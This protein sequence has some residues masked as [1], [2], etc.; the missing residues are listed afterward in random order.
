MHLALLNLTDLMISLWRGTIDCTRPDDKATW[1][2]A[3]F[4]GG[5]LWQQH[6]QAVA[7]ALHYLP[8]SFDR[9]P[10][11][12]A[13][14]LTSSYKAWEFLLYL[15]G[16]GP[17][18][19]YGTLPNKYFTNYCKL[20]LGIWLMNQ[21]RITQDNVRKAHIALLSFAHEFELIYCQ[22]L[23]TC[24]HFVRPCM[25]SLVHLPR[26]VIR[27]GLP[28]CSSQWT[29]AQTIGNLGKE[30]KQHSNPFAN[31]SQHGIRHACVNALVVI[32][33]DLESQRSSGEQ[34]SCGSKDLGDGYIL[35][36][37]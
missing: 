16:L 15:Y 35:L 3:V 28:I 24:I 6:G 36:C 13:E 4:H 19:L 29:L 26:K 18:L 14:K 30:I 31:L 12:I 11:N 10:H 21:H 33:L 5:D 23:Q 20:V 17:G 27:I 9:P 34:G 2:W 22:R 7:D 32:I 8:S 25:H 1:D 37:T